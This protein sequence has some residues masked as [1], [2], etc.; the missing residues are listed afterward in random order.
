MGLIGRVGSGEV[1][2]R[3]G[4]LANVRIMEDEEW[5]TEMDALVNE[6]ERGFSFVSEPPVE[7]S[8]ST[9]YQKNPI[10]QRTFDFS[11]A[12]IDFTEG[13]YEK[14]K[15]V[16]A[17]QLLKSGTSIG[18]NS[19]EAQNAESLADFAHKIKIALKEAD[20]TEYWLLL[21]NASPH[22]PDCPDLIV[23]LKHILRILNKIV[24]TCR[25]KQSK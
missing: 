23:D 11:L 12:I 25:H 6:W 10:V 7:Y 13:L 19:R 24:A 22:Y 14:K 4:Q 5:R 8:S 9:H 20:E 3:I 17:Q 18:A 15:F 16:I 2:E 21:C 1:D